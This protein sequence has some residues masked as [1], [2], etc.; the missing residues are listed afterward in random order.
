MLQISPNTLPVAHTVPTLQRARGDG[1]LAVKSAGG[2][3]RLAVLYQDGCAKIRLPRAAPG[4]PLEAVLINTAGGLTGGDRM[5]WSIAI[6]E[7]AGASVTT[8]ACERI[9]KTTGPAAR[10]ETRVEIAAEGSLAF[11]PQETI[12]FDR[13]SFERSL[14]A[15][16]AAGAR[17][18]VVEPLVFGRQAMGEDVLAAHYRDRWRIR[19]DG[20][21]VHGED[22]AMNGDVHALL[23]HRAVANGA[24]AIA[25][26]LVVGS[27][28]E[29]QL[30]AVRTIVGDDGGAS[31][32][33][34][35]GS[36]KLLARIVAPDSYE[37]RKRLI[38]LIAL[39]NGRAGLPKI[40]T[41]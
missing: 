14:S 39:L 40:W 21:L 30:D 34:V 5:N 19:V 26:V 36:G 38:P 4:A 16:L 31:A 13:S 33:R 28:V 24:R 15:D 1:R 22:V 18:L 8:Q 9:Y 25:T 2:I 17:L 6:G 7:G 29:T 32:W 37:L 41:T 10:V 11:L 12:L 27:D 23:G 20:R 35:G 3:N